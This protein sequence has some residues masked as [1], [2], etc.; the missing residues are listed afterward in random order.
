MAK[1][2]EERSS[3]AQRGMLVFGG[4]VGM[5]RDTSGLEDQGECAWH[6]SLPIQ[7]PG[8]L[9]RL[10]A[11]WGLLHPCRYWEREGEGEKAKLA[12]GSVCVCWGGGVP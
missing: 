5:K 6:S 9:L 8:S 2:R 1:G 4:S 10:Q 11:F 7:H 12:R 3:H